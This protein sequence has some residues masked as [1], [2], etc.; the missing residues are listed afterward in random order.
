[1]IFEKPEIFYKKF[2]YKY[3]LFKAEM[4]Y[5]MIESGEKDFHDKDGNIEAL[6]G[7]VKEYQQML[8]YELHFTYYHQAEALFELVFALERVL[9]ES[10]YVWLEMSQYKPGDMRRFAKKINRISKGSDELRGKKIDLTDGTKISFYEW[11]IF[12]VFVPEMEKTEQQVKTSIEQVDSIVQLAANDLAEKKEY[13]AFKHGM[14]VLHVFKKFNISDSENQK[15]DINFDLKNS[16]T[17]INYPKED[18]EKG[19]NEGDIQ[20]ITKGYNPK[21]DLL[22]IKLITLL[23]AGI[24]ESRKARFFGNGKFM[25]FLDF[26]ID[27]KLNELSPQISNLIYTLHANSDNNE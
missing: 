19:T 5:N 3:W 21:Q 18:K 14:R 12:D 10:E 24:I 2:P 20:A 4:L 13:N 26:D 11:L 6:G 15:F 1:M 27:K 16:F 22:K 23:M 25:E 8:K 9:H 17:Y 7:N